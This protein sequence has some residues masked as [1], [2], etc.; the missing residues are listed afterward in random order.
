MGFGGQPRYSQ[1]SIAEFQF[2]SNRFDATQGR[3]T[4]VQVSAI[5]RSGTNRFCRVGPGQLP[6]Q[7]LQREEPGTRP[8]RAPRESAARFHAG[9]PIMRRPDAL[10]RP[11]RVRARAKNQRLE[12]TVPE[13]QHRPEG[14]DSIKLGG[15]RSGLSAVAEH[16]GSWGKRA[17]GD[18][19]SRSG[20]AIRSHPAATGSNGEPNREVPRPAHTGA[21]QPGVE[22]D[23]GGV[24]EYRFIRTQ[25]DNVVD[26]HWQP[27]SASRRDRRASRSAFTIGG[28]TFFPR[29]GAQEIFSI[30]DEFTFSIQR[31][32][33]SRLEGRRR[34][35]AA[36]GY[37]DNCQVCMGRIDARNGTT[38]ANIEALFPDPFDADTWN[39]AAISPLVR[40][41][42]IGVG[43]FATDDVRPQI[44]VWLQDDWRIASR[45]TLNLGLRYDLS[46]NANGEQYAMH[47]SWRPVVPTTR[48]MC[49][50]ARASP[51]SSTIRRLC[52]VERDCTSRCLCRWKLLDGAGGPAGRDQVTNDGRP[53]F[54][55]DPPTASRCRRSSR[56]SSG[57]A[58]SR[59]CRDVCS[60]RSRN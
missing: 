35:P 11:L 32:R 13:L 52:A 48:T 6:E 39:L 33:T 20:S 18:A 51:T 59:T 40:T 17:R 10:L 55:S 14:N 26:N 50:R 7:S 47:R 4:G 29:F 8:S 19:R 23:E 28:N 27:T 3:S 38:P 44:G 37:G 58:T 16:R 30:R 49:S 57:S 34:I 46:E 24:H 2:I 43:D 36:G 12:H 53:D 54:A 1:D 42:D 41:Y 45:L 9:G 5:T 22:R 31:Q 56:R 21:E 15:V 60:A 25:P